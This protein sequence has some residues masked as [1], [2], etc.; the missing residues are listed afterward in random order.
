MLIPAPREQSRTERSDRRSNRVAPPRR[1]AG[2]LRLGALALGIALALGGCG[3]N[4]AV[5]TPTAIPSSSAGMPTAGGVTNAPAATTNNAGPGSGI[6][7]VQTFSNLARDH[8]DGHV[9]YAQT[10]PVGG[11]HSPVWLNCGI[12]D[13]PAPNENAVHSLEHG[14]VWITYQPDLPAADVQALRGA[15]RGHSYAILSPYPNLPAPVVASAWGVQLRLTEA[16]D[17]RL[18]EF[19]K[20]Y[21]QGPQNPEPGAACSGGRGVP[22]AE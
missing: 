20:Y 16:S 5:G 1:W 19:I 14:A 6:E 18:P 13:K 11:P 7:G 3:A 2:R 8:V 17:P 22:I 9:D 4:S 12:Y 21:E 10:P 15:V